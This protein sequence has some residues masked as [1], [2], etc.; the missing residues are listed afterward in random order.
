MDWLG[1]TLLSSGKTANLFF[2]IAPPTFSLFSFHSQP[3]YNILDF[4]ANAL[5]SPCE[6]VV[7]NWN[8]FVA[9]QI[10]K[11]EMNHRL[12]HHTADRLLR[13]S[14][15]V[16][17][18]DSHVVGLERG[19]LSLVSTTEELLD[20]KVAEKSSGSCLENREYGRRDPS[21]W[22]RG[23]LYPQELTITSPTSGGR[24]VGIVRSRTQTMEFSFRFY[25]RCTK[26]SLVRAVAR[27]NRI[28]PR[29]RFFVIM[30]SEARS[31]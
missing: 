4:A 14:K 9:W 25:S 3:T 7:E 31:L 5:I 22:P 26:N 6:R 29:L 19:P 23:T 2:K 28:D 12:Q 1:E 24:S 20:R 30:F 8:D 15:S 18:F 11:R 16:A 21:L 27:N 13:N 17:R 10:W